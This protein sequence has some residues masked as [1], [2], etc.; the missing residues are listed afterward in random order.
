MSANHVPFRGGRIQRSRRCGVGSG[1]VAA[2]T[3]IARAFVTDESYE[4]GPDDVAHGV[5]GPRPGR[6]QDR[7]E[8]CETEFD[9]IEV[10]GESSVC[11]AAR[12]LTHESAG[13]MSENASRPPWRDSNLADCHVRLERRPGERTYH[14]SASIDGILPKAGSAR[15]LSYELAQG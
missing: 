13:A 11:F 7:F 4:G 8:F 9:R 5:E 2:V 12:P 1:S 3:E 14:G 6:A 10:R 15:D